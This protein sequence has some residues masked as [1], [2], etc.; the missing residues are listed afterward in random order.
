[1]NPLVTIAIPIYNAEHFLHYAIK[2]V[3]DQ[4]FKNWELFLINDGSND[5]SL[6]I[7][8]RFEMDPRI[9]I[10]NDGENRGLIYRLNQSV[11]LA[12]GKYYARMDADDIM[13]PE[14]LLK[15][16]EYME[17][18]PECDVL[19]SS[20]YSIDSKN[21]VIG[22]KT[23]SNSRW[24]RSS[25]LRGSAFIHPSVMGKR[26]WFLSNPYD[27]DWERA[28]DYQ[29]W[30]RT[31]EHSRFHNLEEPLLF[32][33]EVGIPTFGKYFKTQKTIMGLWSKRHELNISIS[34]AAY[35]SVSALVKSIVYGVFYFT[36]N[37][38][39]LISR[40]SNV[41]ERELQERVQK[42]LNNILVNNI[43]I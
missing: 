43:S 16:V 22:I 19:G 33:R 2:S 9:T 37:I 41:L 29:L 35:V 15:Q 11:K 1:M 3:I 27:K 6:N 18:H 13:D 25:L 42:R 21:Y 10:L 24:S 36:G 34:D 17:S 26:E 28:E 23:S 4:S 8:K 5:E 31:V 39:R 20:A 32:Y 38:D 7:M 14:R 30:L 12:K 40:R